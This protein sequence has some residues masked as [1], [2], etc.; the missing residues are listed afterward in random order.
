[1]KKH[2]KKAEREVEG[3][4]AAYREVGRE[5]RISRPFIRVFLSFIFLLLASPAVGLN[6]GWPAWL[7]L[8]GGGGQGEQ[9]GSARRVLSLFAKLE[10]PP[11]TRDAWETRASGR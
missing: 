11:A 10:G 4:I 2:N 7:K 3:I 5:E 8:R 9:I 1:M 6:Q